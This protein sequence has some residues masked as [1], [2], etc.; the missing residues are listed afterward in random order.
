VSTGDDVVRLKSV[1]AVGADGRVR[2]EFSVTEPIDVAVEMWV[3]QG[4]YPL[5]VSLYFYDEAGV[6][7]FMTGDFQDPHWQNMPRPQGIH[8]STCHIPPHLLN[9]G[10]LSVLV[11]VSTDPHTL[12]ALERD[13]ITIRLLDN[14]SPG[15][16]RGA[17]TRDWPGGVVR[18]L[19][20]WTFAFEAPIDGGR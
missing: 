14:L 1:R 7:V 5:S 13:A 9:E 12:H 10:T 8:R 11:G 6:L 20:R 3:L 17:Y 2:A 4:D 16:A 15:G 18:P 19:F